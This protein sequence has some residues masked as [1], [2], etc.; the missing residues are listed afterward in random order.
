MTDMISDVQLRTSLEQRL[1]RTCIMGFGGPS[2]RFVTGADIS[3][4]QIGLMT[5]R[6]NLCHSLIKI[7]TGRLFEVT[8]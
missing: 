5:L 7:F 4:L 1:R 3:S 8:T 2:L 6:S